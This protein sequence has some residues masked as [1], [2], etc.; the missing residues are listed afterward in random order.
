MGIRFVLL[1]LFLVCVGSLSAQDQKISQLSELEIK[2]HLIGN[3]VKTNTDHH[4]RIYRKDSNAQNNRIQFSEDGLFVY[5]WSAIDILG[6]LR[7]FEIESNWNYVHDLRMIYLNS[8]VFNHEN[9]L[10]ILEITADKLVLSTSEINAES[11]PNFQ[12]E[13]KKRSDDQNEIEFITGKIL[14]DARLN[15]IFGKGKILEIDEAFRRKDVKLNLSSPHFYD[16][17]KT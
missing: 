8:E 15:F 10:T 12:S 7:K 4:L 5:A 11:Q 17:I 3:W 13:Y 14:C 9:P 1:C 2:K 16:K 6:N